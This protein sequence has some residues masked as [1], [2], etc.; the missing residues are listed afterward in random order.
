MLGTDGY[1][2]HLMDFV[3]RPNIH[4]DTKAITSINFEIG[5]FYLP[6][7]GYVTGQAVVLTGTTAPT[8]LALTTNMGFPLNWTAITEYWIIRTDGDNFQLAA[9]HYLSM[10]GTA[11]VFSSNGT[12]VSVT[13]LGGGANWHL[14]DDYSRQTPQTVAYTAVDAGTDKINAVAHGFSHMQRVTIASSGSLPSPLVAGTAYWIIRVDADHVRLAQTEDYAFSLTAIDLTTQGS[15]NHT[16]TTSEHFII[17]SDTAA[18]TCNGYDTAGSAWE[19]PTGMAPKFLKLG[20]QTTESGYVRMQGLIWWNSTTHAP[21]GYWVGRRMNSYDSSVFAYQFIGGDEF[22]MQATQLGATWYRMFIDT[23]TAISS[24][25]EPISNVGVLQSGVTAITSTVLPLAAGQEL[26]FTVNKFY[27]LYDFASH[28]WINYVKVTNVDTSAHTVTVLGCTNNFPSGAIL[29]P[30]AHRYYLFGQSSDNG[31]NMSSYNP[32]SFGDTYC[33]IPYYSSY[34]NQGYVFHNQQGAIYGQAA[35]T[36]TTELID[37][38]IPDDEGNYDCVR[39]AI[40]EASFP[41]INNLPSGINRLYGKSSNT[42]ETRVGAM[43]LM[44]NY[45]TMLGVDYL[46]FFDIAAGTYADMITYS[47]SE[48]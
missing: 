14:I 29:T 27:Y 9:S 6:S 34:D 7:H 18:P 22:L 28:C 10:V 13:A 36:Q 43:G 35:Y 15:G 2:A 4:G 12:S 44:V 25:L 19:S 37:A 30:Y 48:T 26:G 46:Y 1:M 16:I 11:L 47:E 23:F 31:I 21:W 24:K 8:G 39:H 41:N 32:Y 45:R 5:S 38:G 3:T 42:L 17:V 33:T 40:K 20:Y